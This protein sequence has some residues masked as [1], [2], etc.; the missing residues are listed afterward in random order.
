[1]KKALTFTA[2]TALLGTVTMAAT[3]SP[4]DTAATKATAT[5][6]D[7][8]A[9]EKEAAGHNATVVTETN[10]VD[11]DAHHAVEANS[12]HPA[13]VVVNKPAK[14]LVAKH[15]AHHSHINVKEADA[16]TAQLNAATCPN[17][18]AAPTA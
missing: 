6:T 10:K 5:A 13:A 15:H 1:M 3:T 2:I 18:A 12:A 9:V 17:A 16:L 8:L 4:H 11:T 7:K 14:K